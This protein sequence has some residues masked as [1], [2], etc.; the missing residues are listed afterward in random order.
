MGWSVTPVRAARRGF[1]LVE[2]L[3]SMAILGLMVTGV[4]SGFIQSHRTAEWS[5]YSL[6]AQ[7]LAL[8][9]MEQSRAAKWDPTKSPAADDLVA[10]NFPTTINI[11]DVPLSGTNIVYATNRIS[12]RTVST[13]PPLR[14]VAV[15]C[16]WKFPNRGL[17]TNSILTY[18][19]P[20][21]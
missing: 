1:T 11:L 3:V 8:Q 14:E 19:A 21:Q 7:S 15:E 4:V 10:S 6:A 12:I 9:A 20:D 18:R 13:D 16:T 17:F 5:A 2:A